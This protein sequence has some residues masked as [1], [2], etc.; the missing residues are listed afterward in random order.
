MLIKAIAVGIVGGA[1]TSLVAWSPFIRDA[2]AYHAVWLAAIVAIYLGFAFMDGRPSIVVLEG[3]VATGFLVLAFLGLW[4]APAFIAAGLFLHAFWDLVHQ[5][6]GITTRL[7]RWYPPFCAAFDF[8][9]AGLFLG[10]ARELGR[11]GQ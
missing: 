10:L 11:H 8:V 2:V 6:R 7:P 1:I 5:P 3:A 9:F 4:Q